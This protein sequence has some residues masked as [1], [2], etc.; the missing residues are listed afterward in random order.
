[1]GLSSTYHPPEEEE[2]E[3]SVKQGSPV[4]AAP[5]VGYCSR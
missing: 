1:M 4:W 2:C 5:A 3:T